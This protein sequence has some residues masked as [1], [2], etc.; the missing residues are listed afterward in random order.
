[1]YLFRRLAAADAQFAR[2]CDATSYRTLLEEMRAAPAYAEM[3]Y[4]ALEKKA[5]RMWD[6][7]KEYRAQQ[8]VMRTPAPPT[9]SRLW[10]ATMPMD[11]DPAP[12]SNT[13]GKERGERISGA[14]DA[15]CVM[16]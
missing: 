13:T 14:A 6:A 16:Q 12:Q 15:A 8:R 7:L 10:I 9:A 4:I 11:M 2:Q 5:G 3:P 1:M